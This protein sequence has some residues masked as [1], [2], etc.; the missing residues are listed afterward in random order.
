MQRIPVSRGLSNQPGGLKLTNGSMVWLREDKIATILK[1]NKMGNDN[2]YAQVLRD[3]EEQGQTYPVTLMW[4]S[5]YTKRVRVHI[6]G[7]GCVAHQDEL[8]RAQV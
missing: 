2:T 3:E 7:R 5:K 6:H 1:R 4:H 8:L